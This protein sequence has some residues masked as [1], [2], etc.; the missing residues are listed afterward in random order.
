MG[1]RGIY[2]DCVLECQWPCG[3]QAQGVFARPCQVLRRHLLLPGDQDQMPA[4][5]PRVPPVL[6]PG[7]PPG[8]FRHADSSA[9]GAH[10]R[11]VRY[12]RRPFR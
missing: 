8:V 11:P 4:L 5:H 10:L 2:E 3:L 9:E 6:E 12:G 1:G 7:Q